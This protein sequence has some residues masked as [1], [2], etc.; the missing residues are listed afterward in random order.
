[1]LGEGGGIDARA[2]DDDHPQRRHP[3]LGLGVRRDDPAQEGT[4]DARAADGDDAHLLVG[5]VAE[6]G[7]EG[8][9]VARRRPGRTR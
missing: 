4:A 7:A 5:L 8:L 1:M 9:A 2:G 3:L 6:L